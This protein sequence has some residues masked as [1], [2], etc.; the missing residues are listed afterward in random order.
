MRLLLFIATISLL[1]SACK[2]PGAIG[3]GLLQG[4]EFLVEFTDEIIIPGK[5]VRGDTIKID[6]LSLFKSLGVLDEPIFGET[7]TQLFVNTTFSTTTD[8]LPDPDFTDATL[9]SIVLRIPLDRDYH[10][11]DTTAMH[12]VEVF[13]LTN[14][15]EEEVALIGSENITTFSS[16]PFDESLVIGEKTFRPNYIDPTLVNAHVVDSILEFE[17]HLRVKIDN[18]FGE[19]FFD[20]ETAI[21]SDSAYTANAKGLLIRSTPTSNSMMGLDLSNQ[22]VHTL[23]FYYNFGDTIKTLYPFDI[24]NSRFLNVI[25]EY[26]GSGSDIEASLNNTNVD[27]EFLYAES[28]SGTNIEFDF[29][30]ILDFQD[31][32]VNYASFEITL[33]DLPDYDTGLFLPVSN[34]LLS[35]R[36]SDGILRTIPDVEE[37]STS[38]VAVL[39]EFYGGTPDVDGLTGET[40]YTMNITKFVNDILTGELDAD[41]TL[42]LSTGLRFTE[43][44]RSIIYGSG[45]GSSPKL[46]LVVTKP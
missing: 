19:I 38:S 31:D 14:T 46:K 42:T 28:Y 29:S 6:S 17:P 34:F 24:G 4:E 2:D 30:Q 10:Y 9:D 45:S 18:S 12:H 11:G 35:Y 26:D 20:D 22:S 5:V 41:L 39:E 3:A 8:L 7:R 44:N 13:Q 40:K 32:I 21:E 36:N 37:L 1:F 15:Y 25:H 23:A 27:Q 43:P 16:L 33:A